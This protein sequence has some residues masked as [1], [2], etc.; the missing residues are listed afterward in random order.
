MGRIAACLA[1]VTVSISTL[2]CKNGGIASW[3]GKKTESTAMVDPYEP[4]A[5]TFYQP[6]STPVYH[7][8]APAEDTYTSAAQMQ[9]TA[10]ESLAVRYHTVAKKETLYAIARSYYGDQRRW[11]EIYE[12]NRLEISDPNRIRIGQRLLIP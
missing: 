12:A 8:P 9:P 10:A 4:P 2:G 11:K 1:I 5:E 3:F 7:Q 6:A